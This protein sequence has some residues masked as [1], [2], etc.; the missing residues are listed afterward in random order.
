MIAPLVFGLAGVA[1]LVALGVWQVQRLAWKE[2]ILA[3]IEARIAE[4][5]GAV[6]SDPRAAE[7]AYRRVEASGTFLPGEIHVYTSAPPH[8]VGYRVIAP[9]VLED[10][11]RILVDR[12]FVPVGEKDAARPLG[13]ARITGSLLWPDDGAAS[14]AAPDLGRNVWLAR[15]LPRM[16]EVLETAPVLV[17]VSASDDPAA[18]MPLPAGV[19]I[20]NDHL[21]YAI[22]WFG[23]AAVWAVMTLTLLW[24]IK[25]R[26]D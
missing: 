19:A 18:P 4:P 11:R 26:T 23:L 2:G 1:V 13:E 15:D 3:R 12:G 21:G 17:V 10:G 20:R 25:R 7:H 8:G 9:F 24:R 5:P 16:A 14:A 22:T 6:P